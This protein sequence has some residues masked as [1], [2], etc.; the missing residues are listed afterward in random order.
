MDAS[1]GHYPF[2]WLLAAGY[3]PEIL[4]RPKH[5]SRELRW[6]D[7]P[8]MSRSFKLQLLTSSFQRTIRMNRTVYARTNAGANLP[9]LSFK[10][11]AAGARI[12]SHTTNNQYRHAAKSAPAIH[13]RIAAPYQTICLDISPWTKALLAL[14]RTL[15][16]RLVFLHLFQRQ[17]ALLTS[18]SSSVFL[19]S[20]F[21]S[22][23]PVI[24]QLPPEQPR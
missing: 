18:M 11:Q 5:R 21:K 23:H 7:F 22:P 3:S 19:I 8:S 12:T 15:N 17:R 4:L 20:T 24:I 2:C 9:L 6:S 16:L 14:P 1:L 13:S 10:A